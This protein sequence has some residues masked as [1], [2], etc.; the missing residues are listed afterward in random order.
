MA[1]TQLA[2][3]AVWV[4]MYPRTAAPGTYLFLGGPDG[5]Q[6]WWCCC[7]VPD[8]GWGGPVGTVYEGTSPMPM[9]PSRYVP[10]VPI[11]NETARGLVECSDPC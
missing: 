3:A 11:K 5:G 2:W 4:V 10:P 1:V 6:V 7:P 8:V 9:P